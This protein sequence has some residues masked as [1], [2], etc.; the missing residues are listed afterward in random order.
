LRKTHT[1]DDVMST[2]DA[3]E[4]LGV[5]LRTVQLWVESG[6]LPAWKTAGGHRRIAR[7]AVERVLAERQSAIGQAGAPLMAPTPPAHAPAGQRPYR[8]LLVEDEPDLLRLLTLAIDGWELPIELTTATNGFE[9]LVRLG[10][11]HPDLLITDLNM[12]GMDGFRMIR[13]LHAFGHEGRAPDIVVV[14]ALDA[15]EIDDRGGLP[16]GVLRFGKPVSF[17]QLEALVRSKLA[18]RGFAA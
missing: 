17:S 5:A 2:R 14:S 4:R 9:A 18:E 11:R 8:V 1:N 16:P 3:A 10:E 7:S 12:P 6:V 13:A 15:N